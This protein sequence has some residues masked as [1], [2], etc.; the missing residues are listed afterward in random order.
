[1]VVSAAVVVALFTSQR[2]LAA[3]ASCQIANVTPLSFPAYTAG[4]ASPV[5]TVGEL[6]VTCS[7]TTTVQISLGRGVSGRLNPRTMTSLYSSLA[8]NIFQDAACTTVWGDGTGGSSL[9][10][11]TVMMAQVLRLSVYGRIYPLQATPPGI[12]RDQITVLVVF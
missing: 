5:D 8:Y 7:A 4:Q 10:T 9:Y 12:Y 2:A 3:G 11:P 1:L 6:D